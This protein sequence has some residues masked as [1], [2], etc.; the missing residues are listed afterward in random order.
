MMFN[1]HDTRRASFRLYL[2]RVPELGGHGSAHRL[3]HI[4]AVEHDEGGV[5]TKLH[6]HLLHSVSSHFQQHL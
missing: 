6:G 1:Q 3:V 4:S 5:A 2:S